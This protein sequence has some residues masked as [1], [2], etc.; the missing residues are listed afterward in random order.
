VPLQAAGQGSSRVIGPRAGWQPWGTGSGSFNGYASSGHGPSASL[1]GLWRLMNLNRPAASAPIESVAAAAPAPAPVPSA[2]P[3]AAKPAPP[4]AAPAPAPAP[5]PTPAPTPAPIP[6]PVPAPAPAPEPAPA[7]S[8]SPTP[9]ANSPA[10]VPTVPGAI[11]P[12][13]TDPFDEHEEP[14][15]DPFGGVPPGG[16]LDPA[17]PK[18][19]LLPGGD[20]SPT[21]EP[22]SI[23]LI[24][25]G[26]LGI[27]GALRRRQLI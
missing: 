8:P 21:P 17:D 26:L 16:G 12:P 14:L 27:L 2:P 4:A 22:G 10:D 11:A 24:G 6:G 7:P 5:K 23:L 13:A 25:T 9:T 19:S 20:P 3:V 18:G 15:P 1:G